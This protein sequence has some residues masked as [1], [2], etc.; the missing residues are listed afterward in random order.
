MGEHY[1]GASLVLR[2]RA[3]CLRNLVDRLSAELLI[4]HAEQFSDQ[5][6]AF[7]GGSISG[8]EP[9]QEMSDLG[10]EDHDQG[11]YTYIDECSQQGVHQS[12]VQ[13]R[14]DHSQDE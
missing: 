3:A 4:L 11:Q 2:H 12:H 6:P 5:L 13:R 7:S 10:L 8:S 1:Q 9:Y 14:H